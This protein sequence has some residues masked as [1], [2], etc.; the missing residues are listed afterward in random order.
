MKEQLAGAAGAGRPVTHHELRAIAN[1]PLPLLSKT[2][3]ARLSR[4]GQ[5][6]PVASRDRACIF[7]A[8]R[9]YRYPGRIFGHNK[10]SQCRKKPSILHCQYRVAASQH[11]NTVG[12]K[13]PRYPPHQVAMPLELQRALELHT[14][15]SRSSWHPSMANSAASDSHLSVDTRPQVQ[16]HQH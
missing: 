12:Q 16:R 3:E 8:P 10:R 11:K 1:P 2:G 9:F 15:F 14:K 7:C 4:K 5:I 13:L 6:S